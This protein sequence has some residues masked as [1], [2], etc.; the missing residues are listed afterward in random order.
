MSAYGDSNTDY[1]KAHAV[2]VDNPYLLSDS[3]YS[4]LSPFQILM[5]GEMH[6]TN[7]PAQFVIG[8]SNL[9]TNKGDSVSV[10]LEIPD[11]WMTNFISS[12]TDSSIYQSYFFSTLAVLDGRES[13]AWASVISHL[14][15]NPRV[16]LFFFDRNEDEG[17]LDDRDST[18]FLKIKKQILL[19][20]NWKM[21]TLSGNAHTMIKSNEK[22]MAMYLRED[23]ELNI[24]TKVC[25]FT[26]Y[27]MQGS[28][29]ANFKHGLE[30]RTFSRPPN[31]FDTTFSFDKY[32]ILLSPKTTFPYTAVY[33]TKDISSSEMVKDNLDLSTIKKELKAIY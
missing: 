1:I 16:Q 21:V 27:Y 8:L 10:G 2:R 6:G 15:N 33:Y 9:L 25:T 19:H 7:E 13:F 28:C 23:K 18:M 4:V 12:H 14:K 17:K 11:G 22:R 26:N 29:R 20:P 3:V 5:M 31:H 30:E 32:M 24:A